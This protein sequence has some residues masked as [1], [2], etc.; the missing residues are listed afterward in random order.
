MPFYLISS[1]VLMILANVLHGGPPVHYFLP[2]FTTLPILLAFYLEKIKLWPFLIL[3]IMLINWIAFIKD[4][5]FYKS[6]IITSLDIGLVSFTK[7]Q[8]IASFIGKDSN[9]LPFSIKRVGPF[10]Y[11]PEN[12][13]QNYKYLLIRSGGKLIENSSNVYTIVEEENKVYVTK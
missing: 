11:F 13:S 5:L 4:P 1:T 12:Y 10:D 6:G 9:G 7:Q 2:L 8:S 3:T